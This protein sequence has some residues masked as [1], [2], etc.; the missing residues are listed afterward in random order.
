MQK[1][2]TGLRKRL[3][4]KYNRPLLTVA[5]LAALAQELFRAMPEAERKADRRM[6]MAELGR[7][8]SPAKAEAAR[9]NGKKGGRPRKQKE[10]LSPLW[11]R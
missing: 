9:E 8:T 2:H 10:R 7:I 1:K 4:K 11:P 5:N 3:E 6:A